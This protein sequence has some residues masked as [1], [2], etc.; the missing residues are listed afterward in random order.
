MRVNKKNNIIA[1]TIVCILSSCSTPYP[2][3][4][5]KQGELLYNPKFSESEI[6]EVGSIL[7]EASYFTDESANTIVLEKEIDSIYLRLV[8]EKRYFYDTSFDYSFR[9]L[10]QKI[11][12]QVFPHNTFFVELSDRS[13]HVKRRIK[14]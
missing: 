3:K 6:E 13:L 1:L 9:A 7:V 12:Q 8:V 10:S 5:I 11:N 14:P 4:V 2:K